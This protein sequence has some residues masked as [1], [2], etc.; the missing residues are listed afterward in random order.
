M[1][2]TQL[3]DHSNDVCVWVRGWAWYRDSWCWHSIAEVGAGTVARRRGRH[4]GS[5]L[6]RGAREPTFHCPIVAIAATGGSVMEPCTRAPPPR[7]EA[8]GGEGIPSPAHRLWLRA[9]SPPREAGGERAVPALA[10]EAR[11]PASAAHDC[12]F[13]HHLARRESAFALHIMIITVCSEGGW[14]A[15]SPIMAVNEQNAVV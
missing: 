15:S 6:D 2:R 5:S 3:C 4:F 11:C 10:H 8:S 1:N 7:L 14:V 9:P 12:T 13:L